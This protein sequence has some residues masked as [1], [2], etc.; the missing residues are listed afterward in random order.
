MGQNLAGK[1]PYKDHVVAVRDQ[2]VGRASPPAILVGSV[3]LTPDRARR[4]DPP[5]QF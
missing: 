3:N 5:E 4:L 1:G 2:L